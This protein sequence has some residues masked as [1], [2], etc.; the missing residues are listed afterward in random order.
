MVFCQNYL[1]MMIFKLGCLKGIFFL[2]SAEKKGWGPF[3][4]L[5]D[6]GHNSDILG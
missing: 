4:G 5:M 2:V 3:F 6:H 1:H